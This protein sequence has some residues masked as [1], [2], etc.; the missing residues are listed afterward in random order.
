M[1]WLD[2]IILLPLLIGLVRGLMRGF[3]VELTAIVAIILGAI[4]TKMWGAPFAIWLS[5]QFAWP[6]AVC[7][8]VAYALLFLG[9]TL[10]LNIFA[11]LLSKL[12]KAVHLGW[13]N[14]LF[15]AV[16][17][18]AKWAAIVLFIVLCVHR[19]DEQFHFFKPELKQQSTIY[20]YI[21]PLSE[22]AWTKVKEQVTTYSAK[23]S[24]DITTENQSE[25]EQE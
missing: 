14:R 15:G 12:F 22:Q 25:N 3:V 4:G 9:I 18:V 19:L 20:S 2:I 23:K 7:S 1:S 5:Q 21:T 10:L 24:S 17:G 13:L 6:E 16:F 11:K 8:V